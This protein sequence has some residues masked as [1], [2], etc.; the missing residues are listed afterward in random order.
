VCCMR[1]NV[2]VFYQI[3]AVGYTA[4]TIACQL[5]YGTDWQLVCTPAW[6]LYA[7]TVLL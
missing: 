6:Q 3:E 2:I 7:H 4:Y 5:V 1:N